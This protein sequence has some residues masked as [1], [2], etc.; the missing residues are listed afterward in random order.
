MNATDTAMIAPQKPHT[1]IRRD[2]AEP[3]LITISEIMPNTP[4]LAAQ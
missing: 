3:T 1:R 4:A 2:L